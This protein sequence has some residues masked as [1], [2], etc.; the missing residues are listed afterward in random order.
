[1]RLR[2]RVHQTLEFDELGDAAAFV[3]EYFEYYK[4]VPDSNKEEKDAAWEK[5]MILMAKFG[6][7]F[8]SFTSIVIEYR[9]KLNEEL[10]SE[11]ENSGRGPL[12]ER[13]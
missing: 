1:M 9:K 8:V 6:S 3:T 11:E 10:Q 5:Y 2:L 13:A 12:E 7:M 4:S